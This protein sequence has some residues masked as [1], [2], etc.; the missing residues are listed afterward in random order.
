MKVLAIWMEVSASLSACITDRRPVSRALCRAFSQPSRAV[1]LRRA[2]R[3]FVTETFQTHQ[4]CSRRQDFGGATIGADH[5]KEGKPMENAKAIHV[6]TKL[7]YNNGVG[8]R[9]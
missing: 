8:H 2:R 6:Q 4:V 7:S 1:E 5:R 3:I 9:M